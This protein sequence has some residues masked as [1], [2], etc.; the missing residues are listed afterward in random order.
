ML[1]CDPNLNSDIDL[2]ET[3]IKLRCSINFLKTF[4]VIHDCTTYIQRRI[5]E[6]LILIVSSQLGQELLTR[7][8]NLTQ[9]KV[10]YIYT[11]DKDASATLTKDFDKVSQSIVSTYG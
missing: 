5:D 10:V 9:V 7:V 3:Q 1:W 4:S 11:G 6:K 2:K 8:H